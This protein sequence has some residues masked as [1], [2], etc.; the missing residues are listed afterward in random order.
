MARQARIEQFRGEILSIRKELRDVQLSLRKDIQG[1]ETLVKFANIAAIPIL[2]A[3]AAVV[4][5]WARTRRRAAAA[6]R[7]HNGR[8]EA[9]A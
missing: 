1:L 5:A 6:R 4:L 2:I 3:F 7:E 9:R 8:S